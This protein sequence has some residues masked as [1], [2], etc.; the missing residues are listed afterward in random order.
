LGKALVA[1]DVG[2]L[3]KCP[4]C[5]LFEKNCS[6]DIVCAGIERK[7]GKNVVFKLVDWPESRK[8]EV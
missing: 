4:E 8:E 2:T 3:S 7:D 5:F 6:D 1:V